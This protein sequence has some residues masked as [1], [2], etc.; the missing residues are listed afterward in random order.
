M[1]A[2]ESLGLITVPGLAFTLAYAADRSRALKALVYV[3]LAV[4][5]LTGL[6]VGAAWTLVRIGGPSLAAS[7]NAG[8]SATG[9][10]FAAVV[11]GIAGVAPLIL[12][13][14]MVGVVLFF[15]PSRRVLARVMPIDP[16][17]LP[18]LVALHFALAL[19]IVAV[20]TA[21]LASVIS[22]DEAALGRLNETAKEA[23]LW[24]LWAQNIGLFLFALLGIGV[25]V[26][27][28]VPTA[29]H[30]L[31][32]T[33]WVSVRW[34]LAVPALGLAT[35]WLVDHWWRAA[36]PSS[37]AGV[38]RI[39]DALFSSYIEAG[40]L[41]VLAVA[42]AGIGEE[43]VFRGAA[44]PRFGLV[45]TALLFAAIH[46]Q[47]TVSPALVQV[48]VLGVLLGLARLRANTTTAMAAHATYNGILVL[49][50]IY[51]PDLSQ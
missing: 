4:A 23:G 10:D 27:R 42:S 29:L 35:G 39:A 38:N 19:V 46:T 28:D 40:I 1:S 16:D 51:A 6:A 13:I 12:A 32:V 2:I 11:E 33:G 47:Y 43:A 9:L 8:A 30:R 22:G 44:Q 5:D 45:V 15:R 24:G 25:F 20:L 3:G 37:L 50:A 49:L 26:R 17:S 18:H 31:G 21:V 48:F 14:S 7:P 41:G 34:W 36:D